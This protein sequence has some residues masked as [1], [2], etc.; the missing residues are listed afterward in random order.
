M[1]LGDRSFWSVLRT[2]RDVMCRYR[3]ADREYREIVVAV[4]VAV[5]VVVMVEV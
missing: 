4:V 1:A 3:L 2:C 5:V